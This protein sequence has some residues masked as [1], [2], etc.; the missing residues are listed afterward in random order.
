MLQHRVVSDPSLMTSKRVQF[1]VRGV[2]YETL[3]STLQRFPETLLGSQNKRRT[4]PRTSAD[5]ILL[6]CSATSF[7]A[8]LFYYQSNGILI[9]PPSLSTADFEELCRYF[10]IAEIDICKMKERD[11][12]VLGDE[13][14]VFHFRSTAHELVFQFIE[15]PQFSTAAAVYA[16]IVY[17]LIFL[18]VLIGCFLTLPELQ[19]NPSLS[20]FKNGMLTFDVIL[21]LFF[22]LELMVRFFIHPQKFHFLSS[23]VN[24]IDI[25]SIVPF[26]ILQVRDVSANS[27][28]GFLHVVRT[29]RVLRLLRVR[30]QSKR[31]QVVFRILSDCIID[32][33]TMILAV[34]ISSLAYASIVFYVEQTESVETQFTSIPNALWWAIQTIIPLG[35]GDIVPRSISGKFAAG[36]VCILAAFSF[37]VPVLFLGGKFLV[38]YSRSFGMALGNDFKNID[39]DRQ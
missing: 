21:N 22:L 3:E 32:V 6:H 4:L 11:G 14:I 26:L 23:G 39:N 12:L 18:S 20:T 25:I 15:N 36:M 10:D 29:F 37:T 5:L 8:I 34:A 38:L 35:Y 2:Y 7:D 27:S 13:N 17:V 28:A 16:Y 19:Q 9:R 1:N 30:K 33:I 31:L 24:V